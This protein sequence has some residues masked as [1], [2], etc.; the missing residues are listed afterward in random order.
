[1]DMHFFIRST[2]SQKSPRE[3]HKGKTSLSGAI[4]T[5]RWVRESWK[6]DCVHRTL[7]M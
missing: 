3:S 5:R 6:P 7:C 1:M 2:D 4:R